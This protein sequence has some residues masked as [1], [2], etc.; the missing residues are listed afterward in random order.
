MQW[1]WYTILGVG[2]YLLGN[3][4][5]GKIIIWRMNKKGLEQT[6]SGNVGTMNTMRTYGKKIAILVLVGDTL[7]GLI[8]ALVGYLTLG[9]LGLYI[10]GTAAVL[11]HCFPVFFKFKGGKGIATT[12][13]MFL[14]ANP[15]ASGIA[16]LCGIIFILIFEYGGFASLMFIAS[17]VIIEAIANQGNIGV[18][19]CLSLIFIITW[20]LHRANIVRMFSGNE[21]RLSFRKKKKE[22]EKG[23]RKRKKKKEK[24]NG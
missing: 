11:G 18:L 1:L 21:N 2:A 23:K 20:R 17:L 12:W 16:F 4:L 15:L 24:Q 3:V 22:K 7:K 6:G 14:V 9:T 10:G 13:G 5:F 19:I 8:P